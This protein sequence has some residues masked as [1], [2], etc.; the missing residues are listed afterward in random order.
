MKR[1]L[2]AFV[3]FLVLAGLFFFGC[4]DFW[5]PEGSQKDDGKSPGS[6]PSDP[7]KIYHV[8][9]GQISGGSLMAVPIAGI[10]GTLITVTLIPDPGTVLLSGSL[11]FNSTPIN[12]STRVFSMPATDVYLTAR[13]IPL[14]PPLLNEY[15]P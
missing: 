14:P 10:Q 13:F 1:R 6:G 9:L 3:L 11:Y 8:Y 12:E 15:G 4:K 2:V 5:H 7:N